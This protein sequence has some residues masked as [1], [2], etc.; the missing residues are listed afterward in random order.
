MSANSISSINL[1]DARSRIADADIALEMMRV[2]Q[3]RTLTEI[4]VL[5]QRQAQDN[6]ENR[7]NRVLQTGI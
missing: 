7:V 5:M 3:D 2:S 1:A 4:Q 6:E